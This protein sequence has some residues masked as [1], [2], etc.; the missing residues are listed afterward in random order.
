[1][2][3]DNQGGIIANGPVSNSNNYNRNKISQTG[4]SIRKIQLISGAVGFLLGVV[5]SVLGSYI[6]EFLSH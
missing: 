5:A 1:M 6:Y 3:N 4:V 2:M